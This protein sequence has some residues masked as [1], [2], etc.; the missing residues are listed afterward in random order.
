MSLISLLISHY[1]S[2]DTLSQR[3]IIL[4]LNVLLKMLKL[5]KYLSLPTFNKKKDK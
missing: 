5:K 1:M 4:S 3:I 2:L